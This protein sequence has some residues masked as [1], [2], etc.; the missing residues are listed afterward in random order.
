M[1]PPTLIR[2]FQALTNRFDEQLEDERS[3]YFDPDEA[4]PL[5]ERWASVRDELRAQDSELADLAVRAIPASSGT[6]DY[7]N[8]GYIERY[9]FERVRS[10]M[11]DAWDILNHPGRQVAQVELKS[12][13]IFLAGEPFD[14][15][16][17][18]TSIIRSSTTSITVVDGYVSEATLDLLS[19]KAANVTARVLT[20]PDSAKPAFVRHGTAFVAQYGAL[21]VRTSQAFH[22]RFLVID[23]AT[24]YHFGTS[25]KDAGRKKA[26]MFSRIEEPVVLSTLKATLA[27]EWGAA[28][29]VQL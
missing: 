20:Y 1:V 10:D 25:L 15:M 29:T 27:M 8:R 18:I 6:T 3:R 16:L 22:D 7:Q 21:E 12:E 14:A 13:G 19:T 4:I 24:Y 26:F 28:A 23:D 5:F 17:A 9:H 11:R 2:K